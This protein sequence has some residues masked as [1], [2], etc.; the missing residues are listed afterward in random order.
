[1]VKKILIITLFIFICG[2]QLS[3]DPG[4][5]ISYTLLDYLTIEQIDSVFSVPPYDLLP[6]SP[7]YPVSIYN[8]VY[9]TLDPH[10]NSAVA[11]GAL[12]IPHGADYALPFL[13][14]HHGTVVLRDD[15]PSV[16][17]IDGIYG[18]IGLWGAASGYI[19]L[20]PDY[21]GLGVSEILHPYQ[22]AE[23]SATSI[24]DFIL[25]SKTFG[26]EN[27]ISL[28]DQLFLLG[29]SE[30]GYTTVAAQ[31]MIEEHYPDIE[32]TASAAGAGAYDMS[33]TMVDLMLDA[34]EYASPFY[35]PYMLFAYNDMYTLY[36]SP[37]DYLKDEYADVLPPLFDGEH[38]S[39]EINDAMP[40]IP[41]QILK[42]EVVQDFTVNNNHPLRIALR[43]ND[44]YDWTPLSPLKLFHS[45]DDEQ[46]PY[47]NSVIAYNTFVANGAP[48]VELIPCPCGSHAD[49][50]IIIL[51]GAFTWFEQLIDDSTALGIGNPEIFLPQKESLTSFPNPFNAATEIVFEISSFSH[52]T[53]NAYDVLGRRVESLFNKSIEPG[54]YRINWDAS[55]LPSGTYFV[56]MSGESLSPFRQNSSFQKTQKLV[57][58][59]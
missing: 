46:V 32:I 10:N 22:L 50:A 8:V 18:L 31:K 53:I 48:D 49:A 20:L 7:K 43:E 36:D 14:F 52:V 55:E 37:S 33:G 17:G 9:E 28:N 51:L 15:V 47:E 45:P 19:T 5:L 59:K 13:S 44:L 42:D 57:L 12:A 11:S 35:L 58:L 30:G 21:L 38:D 34:Q 40:S 23:P 2:V 1:M 24:V 41:I 16:Y 56:H 3:A 6:F 25:A 29:Y 4:D 27:A 26:N 39:P 54:T